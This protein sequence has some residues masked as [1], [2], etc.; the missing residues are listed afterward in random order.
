M[1]ETEFTLGIEEEYQIIDAQTRELRP[2]SNVVLEQA[3]QTLVEQ[4]AGRRKIPS[5][6]GR[7][8]SMNSTSPRSKRLRLYVIRLPISGAVAA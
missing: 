7:S 6:P 3:Q 2:R 5:K 8:C 1:P 4:S